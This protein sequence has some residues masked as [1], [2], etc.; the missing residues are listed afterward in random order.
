VAPDPSFPAEN[1]DHAYQGHPAEDRPDPASF[2]R[3]LFEH[4]AEVHG[5]DADLYASR[6]V[7]E[8]FELSP[9]LREYGEERGLI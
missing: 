2:A 4:L 6:V 9:Q 5:T 1:H 7:A 3:Q 8:L